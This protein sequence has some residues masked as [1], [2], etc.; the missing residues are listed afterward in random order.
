M[1]SGSGTSIVLRA[2]GLLLLVESAGVAGGDQA[3]LIVGEGTVAE[4]VGGGVEAAV[5]VIAAQGDAVRPQDRN[6]VL[7]LERAI[8]AGGSGV[9]QHAVHSALGGLH[10]AA[11]M[12]FP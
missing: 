8:P 10:R 12:T 6:G 9:E 11:A 4:V 3:S 2:I 7:D 1:T 5:R